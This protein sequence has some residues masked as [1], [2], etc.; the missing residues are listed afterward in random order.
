MRFKNRNHI[1]NM[2][3]DDPTIIFWKTMYQTALKHG[4]KACMPGIDPTI[5]KVCQ[6]YIFHI[7]L[8]AAEFA[9]EVVKNKNLPK[10]FIYLSM[11]HCLTGIRTVV[12]DEEE[13][14]YDAQ[15]RAFHAKN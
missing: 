13:I 4:L 7:P 9:A 8:D 11:D 3:V 1:C 12:S 15:I 10:F 6:C 14:A 2:N 5:N